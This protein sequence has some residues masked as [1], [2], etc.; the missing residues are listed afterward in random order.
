MTPLQLY[1]QLTANPAY[2][3]QYYQLTIAGGPIDGWTQ[4]SFTPRVGTFNPRPGRI[5]GILNMHAAQAFQIVHA[6][7]VGPAN[8]FP[9]F[10]VRMQIPGTYVVGA[11]AGY[12]LPEPGPPALM[13][14]G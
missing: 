3:L 12:L 2:I 8:V 6:P 7:M 13:L 4:F 1:N 14:T 5:L 10:N 9:A 11:I